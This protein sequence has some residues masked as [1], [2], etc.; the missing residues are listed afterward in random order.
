MKDI[1]EYFIDSRSPIIEVGYLKED[2]DRKLQELLQIAL[3]GTEE[4]IERLEEL[5]E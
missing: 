2:V 1:R 5:I 3:K 4:I